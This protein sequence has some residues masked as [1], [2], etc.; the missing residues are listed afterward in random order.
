MTGISLALNLILIGWLC[1]NSAHRLDQLPVK[2]DSKFMKKINLAFLGT[3]GWAKK[4]HLPL[5]K[6]FSSRDFSPR[7]KYLWSLNKADA[8]DV[9][10]ELD[11]EGTEPT[12]SLETLCRDSRIDGYVLAINP[13]GLPDVLPRLVATGKPI[14]TEKPTGLRLEECEA[15]ARLVT[16]PNLVGFNRR[17]IPLNRKLKET[18]DSLPVPQTFRATFF[19]VNRDE[20]YFIEGTLIHWINFMEYLLGP[21]G[22][23]KIALHHRDRGTAFTLSLAMVS[24]VS[25]WMQVYSCTGVQEE[26]VTLVGPDYLLRLQGPLNEDPGVLCIDRAEESNPEILTSPSKDPRRFLGFHHEYTEFF[27]RCIG[28]GERGESHFANA[29]SSERI[30]RGIY[31]EWKRLNRE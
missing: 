23:C 16:V 11:L 17:Y 3:G 2:V 25:G 13:R 9:I 4:H 18:L 5:L 14:F 15:H 6:N 22:D 28:R 7:I 31:D 21:I 20:D 24:G 10:S 27:S 29:L 19:R 12:D 1:K 26:T 30:A 8:Q